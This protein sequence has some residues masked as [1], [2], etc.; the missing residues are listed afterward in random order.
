MAAAHGIPMFAWGVLG[1]GLF[2]GK[3]LHPQDGPR[4]YGQFEPSERVRQLSVAI[5]EAAEQVSATPAQTALAWIRAGAW[6]AHVVPIVGVR[7]VEQL[8]ENLAAKPFELPREVVEQIDRVVDFK[9]GYPGEF[10]KG[11]EVRS[12]LFG[13]FDLERP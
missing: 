2:T 8:A 7:T 11:E 13:G 5:V 12:L 3:Y 9:L 6:A 10:L 1:G 4:R